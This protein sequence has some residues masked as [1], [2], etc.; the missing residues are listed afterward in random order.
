MRNNCFD[1]NINSNF[2]E[3]TTITMPIASGIERCW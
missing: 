3:K 1:A 2:T